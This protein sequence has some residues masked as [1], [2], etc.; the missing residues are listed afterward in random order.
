MTTI[1]NCEPKKYEVKLRKSAL[2]IE[3]LKL[4]REKNKKTVKFLGDPVKKKTDLK[5]FPKETHWSSLEHDVGSQ[6]DM[7]DDF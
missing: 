3:S 4:E 6:L 1:S 2:K 7:N 5:P